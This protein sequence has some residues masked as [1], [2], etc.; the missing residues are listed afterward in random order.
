MPWNVWTG[1]AGLIGGFVFGLATRNVLAGVLVAL[2]WGLF[3]YLLPAFRR[4]AGMLTLTAVLLTV[5]LAF[6]T[7]TV[8]VPAQTGPEYACGTVLRDPIRN[9]VD[10]WYR[11]HSGTVAQQ[12]GHT[13]DT[14]R[15]NAGAGAGL[16]VV[17]FGGLLARERRRMRAS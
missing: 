9:P 3:G 7:A 17:V 13:L 11:S 2:V 8:R 14:F 5:A 1:L 12:C 4:T 10:V 16:A 6:A 15:R